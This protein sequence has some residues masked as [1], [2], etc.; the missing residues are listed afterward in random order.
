MLFA[1]ILI[2]SVASCSR[3]DSKT[4]VRDESVLPE[5]SDSSE[6]SSELS[7]SEAP[8]VDPDIINPLTGLY[9]Y[10]K[11]IKIKRPIAIMISNSDLA[12][13][14]CGIENADVI[15]ETLAEGGISRLMGIY[16]DVDKIPD[17]GPIRSARQYY[18]SI[19]RGFDAVFMHWGG[20][21]YANDN[22]RLGGISNVDANQYEG[23]YYWRDP[24]R[25]KNN[26]YEHSGFTNGEKIKEAISGLNFDT[27]PKEKYYETFKFNPPDSPVIPSGGTCK[28]LLVPYSQYSD[29]VF[30]YDETTKLYKKT[31]NGIPQIDGTT[32]KQAEVTNLLVLFAPVK[33]MPSSSY[34]DVDLTGGSGIYV[35]NGS[36]EEITWEKGD[37]NNPFKFKAKNG[38][39]LV[40][41][42]GRS[43]INIFPLDK[44]GSVVTK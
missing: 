1:I 25:R 41:N 31:Q 38:D 34:I 32:K 10:N 36:Y 26:G 2:L 20:S 39:D 13:P 18:V 22:L 29:G 21:V 23:T 33:S 3:I 37:M 28:Q 43:W 9:N 40:I 11:D 42:A 15:F 7:S 35:S 19:A 6:N 4:L 17:I 8:P 27:T 44:K 14:Q 24:D 30:D 5:S 16:S 12:L